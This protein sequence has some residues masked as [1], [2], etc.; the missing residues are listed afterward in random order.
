[1]A[2]AELRD[3]IA[4]MTE[5]FGEIGKLSKS[6]QISAAW[7]AARSNVSEPNHAPGCTHGYIYGG[8]TDRKHLTA[9]AG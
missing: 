2:A 6:A 5:E 9:D 3:T 1:M 7:G 8:E 4:D